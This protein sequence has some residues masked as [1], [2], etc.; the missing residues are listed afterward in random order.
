MRAGRFRGGSR[1]RRGARRPASCAPG[2]GEGARGRREVQVSSSLQLLRRNRGVSRGCHSKKASPAPRSPRRKL[3][4]GEAPPELERE[5]LR[6]HAGSQAPHAGGDLR[7]RNPCQGREFRVFS[8][9]LRSCWKVRP[10]RTHRRKRRGRLPFLPPLH[11]CAGSSR[12]PSARGVRGNGPALPSRYQP[13]H[14]RA[15][16]GSGRGRS[17]LRV[18]GAAPRDAAA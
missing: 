11:R 10:P 14:E 9:G 6:A 2:G 13:V 12:R 5:L 1:P 16:P 7:H 17:D 3:P 4:P 18:Q 15:G 8:P